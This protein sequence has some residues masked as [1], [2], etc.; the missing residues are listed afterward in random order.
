[1]QSPAGHLRPEVQVVSAP[2]STGRAPGRPVSASP[3]SVAR[4]QVRSVA[5]FRSTGRAVAESD[6]DENDLHESSVSAIFEAGPSHY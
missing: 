6:R 5:G 1:V 3:G 2:H 4:L